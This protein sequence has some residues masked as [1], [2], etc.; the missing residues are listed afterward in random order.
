M[1]NQWEAEAVRLGYTSEKEMW[2]DLYPKESLTQLSKKFGKAINSIRARIAACDLP[3]QSRGGA[4]NVRV[5]MDQDLIDDVIKMGVVKSALKRGVRPQV[6][7]SRLY[8]KYGLTVKGLK[9]ASQL[10]TPS[11]A[12]CEDVQPSSGE[13][14]PLAHEDK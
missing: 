12:E 13:L 10:P 1:Q 2:L 7:Y 6:I 11:S 14:P 4:N 3:I 8:Y 5:E 9:E